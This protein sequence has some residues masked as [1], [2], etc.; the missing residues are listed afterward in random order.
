MKHSSER[1][2][3]THTGSLARPP[4]LIEAMGAAS[5]G[6]A[7]ARERAEAMLREEVGAI[8]RRQVEIGLDIIDDGELGKPSFLSYVNDRLGGFE[9]DPNSA[10]SPWKNSREAASFPEFYEQSSR[11][12]PAAAP[13]MVCSGPIS[14]RGQTLVRR[15]I[16]NFKAA[17]ALSPATE[18]FMPAISPADVEHWQRN[19]YYSTQEE[20]L[21]A[22]AEAMREEYQEI[23]AAGLLLQ[24]DDPQLATYY[25]THPAA[26]IEDCRRWAITRVE[27]IN[28]A[29]RGIPEEK[30]R[31][32]T[33][34]GI[35]M[36]PRIHDMEL[37]DL[38][39]IMLRVNA[40]A[41]SFE[42]ANPRHEHEWRLWE[43]IELPRGKVIIP[44]VIT[45][46]SVLVEHPELVA[47]RIVRFA[48]VV[49]R[50]RVIAGSD[51]GFGTFASPIPEIH[52][53]IAWAKL[54]AL[55]EGARLATRA[56]W[57]N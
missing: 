44:G 52:P 3:T 13:H 38:A 53:T 4:Q 30:I 6:A 22:I 10:A 55:V 15:D 2:L 45:H 48:S 39:D 36:G 21:Y 1:I 33:C 17:L 57:K 9:L 31:F 41:Y 19:A 49:G 28:H 5:Q 7:G 51:C 11:G 34:Y 14:Y 42:S 50:E 43:R 47:E 8:V 24:I 27:A 54:Q 26:S 23:I 20:F 40:G 25:T 18:A 35:N 46:C 37:K 16:A 12:A 32:H 29:L 56:L